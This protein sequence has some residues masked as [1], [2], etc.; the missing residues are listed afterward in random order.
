MSRVDPHGRRDGHQV[1]GEVVEDV[2]VLPVVEGIGRLRLCPLDE[3]DRNQSHRQD[4]M[5][6]PAG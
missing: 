5:L 2:D 1:V 4:T 3:P 6:R